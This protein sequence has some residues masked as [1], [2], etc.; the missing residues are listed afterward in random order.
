[1]YLHS[2]LGGKKKV[3]NIG[4]HPSDYH[5]LHFLTGLFYV[6]PPTPKQRTEPKA[7]IDNA[8]IISFSTMSCWKEDLPFV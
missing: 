2:S 5:S 6:G 1:M 3:K 8:S 4:M 7:I